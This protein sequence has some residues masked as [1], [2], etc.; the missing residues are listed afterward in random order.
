MDLIRSARYIRNFT[1]GVEDSLVSTVGVLS[2]V[3]AAN[4]PTSTII[5]SGVV[6]I[7]V[8]AFSMG[9]GSLLSESSAEE[10]SKQR[11]V[12]TKEPMV[13]SLIM[14]SS[15]FLAGLIPL[16]PY[17]ILDTK[18]AFWASILLSLISLFLLGALI[19]KLSNVN[20]LRRG[21]RMFLIGGI[22]IAIGV[23]VGIAV[24][25]LY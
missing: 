1:F 21:L 17:I 11:M 13:A 18:I 8:E 25:K 14:F 22:A 3:A 2:G 19:A 12:P 5:L 7:F 23:A 4:A 15:Y 24:A 10:F 9:V 16:F 6:L 20:V